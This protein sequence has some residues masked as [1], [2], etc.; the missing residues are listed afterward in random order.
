MITVT[1]GYLVE[2][3]PNFSKAKR[4]VQRLNNCVVDLQPNDTPPVEDYDLDRHLC[5]SMTHEQS[6][7]RLSARGR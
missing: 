7:E 1:Q 5:L 3:L 6:V 2:D 4:N